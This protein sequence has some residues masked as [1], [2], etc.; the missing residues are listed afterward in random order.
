MNAV[1]YF[2]QGNSCSESI[3]LSSSD[4]GYCPRD[5]LSLATGFSGGI[6]SGCICGA[7]SAAIMVIG[8]LFGKE[9]SK[10]NPIIARQL[11]KEFISKFKEK[12]NAT[13]CR[14]LSGK[15]EMGSPERK[16]NCCNFVQFCSK[17]LDDVLEKEMVKND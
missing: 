17:L 3:I 9:N 10:N 5:L 11:S 14:V 8:Y 12:Y 2:M 15:F 4:K 7:V 13:C 16:Q 1:E 6:G